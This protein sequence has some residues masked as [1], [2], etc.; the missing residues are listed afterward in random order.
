MKIKQAAQFCGLTEKAIR[1][2]E[3][4]GLTPL[5]APIVVL[6]CIEKLSRTR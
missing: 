4:R 5:S 3:S 6:I 1:L 2:Y